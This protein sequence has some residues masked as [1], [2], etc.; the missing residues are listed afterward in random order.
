M[1]VPDHGRE[2]LLFDGGGPQLDAVNDRGVE[3]VDAGVDAVAD[4]L[5]GLLDEAVDTRGVVGLVNDDTV[6]GR[7]LHLGHHNG[8]LVS[9]GLV[10]SG[11]LLE[12]VFAGNVGVE[13]K[14]RSIIL[15][16]NLLGQLEWT[17]GTQGLVFDRD[18]NVDTE[19][20]LVL[21]EGKRER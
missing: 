17:S 11:E 12:G 9:V 20:L 8:T 10:E 4:E 3:N 5:Y 2:G 16:E 14:E 21:H 7:L 19:L 15:P 1:S 13:D 18:G 6:L